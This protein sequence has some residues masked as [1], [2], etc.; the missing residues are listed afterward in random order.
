[1]TEPKVYAGLKNL[2]SV[3]LIVNHAK[4]LTTKISWAILQRN[5]AQDIVFV[6][7][8]KVLLTYLCNRRF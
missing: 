6:A 1:M 7:K 3:K 2:Q 8:Q 4:V 5:I